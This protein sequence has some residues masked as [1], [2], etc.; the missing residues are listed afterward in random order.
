LISLLS[1]KLHPLAA[2]FSDGSPEPFSRFGAKAAS[3]PAQVKAGN[4]RFFGSNPR[5]IV[6]YS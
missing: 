1:L 3:K 2:A 5:M 6:G 4:A